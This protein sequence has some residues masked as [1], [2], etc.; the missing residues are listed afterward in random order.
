MIV[1]IPITVIFSK[2]MNTSHNSVKRTLGTCGLYGNKEKNEMRTGPN[3]SL[4]VD[5]ICNS[6][7]IFWRKCIKKEESKFDTEE[8]ALQFWN[9]RI[10]K[11]KTEHPLS[12]FCGASR[13][14]SDIEDYKSNHNIPINPPVA[15]NISSADNN[16]GVST[17]TTPLQIIIHTSSE[18]HRKMAISYLLN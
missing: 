16:G 1:N 2:I 5:N 8:E 10:K 4:Q 11:Y 18:I 13:K 12:H 6:C 14:L 9:W 15:R 17:S 7:G 3:I